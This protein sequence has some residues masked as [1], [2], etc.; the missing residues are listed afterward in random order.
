MRCASWRS[1]L[2]AE[3]FA[4]LRLA[5]E[6]DL[7]QLL[8]VGFEVGEQAHLLE[9]LGREVLRLIDHQHHALAGGVRTQQ[10]VTEDVDQVLEAAERG[11]GH[12][13][14]QFLADGQQELRRGHPRVEDQRDFGVA[15]GLRQQRAHDGGLAGAH[16]AG[17]LHEAAGFVDAVQ[18]VRQRFRVPL[19]QVQVARIRCDREGLFVEAEERQVHGSMLLDRVAAAQ[20]LAAEAPAY[21]R[22]APRPGAQARLILEQ[23]QLRGRA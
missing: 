1:S 16:L 7:Q 5:D 23:T 22:P 8:G 3:Q 18:Q 21:L 13:D 12:A 20:R 4:Q 14:A 19:A 10:V 2:R 15:R 17:E 6:D 11:V 9:H